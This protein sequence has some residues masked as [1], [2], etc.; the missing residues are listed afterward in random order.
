MT[1][2]AFSASIS[3]L[4][5][6]DR[7]KI[8]RAFEFGKKAHEGQVRKSGEPYFKHPI[9]TAKILAKMGADA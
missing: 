7:G 9:A 6:S 8:A 4:G 1:F 5:T 3:Y 2:D